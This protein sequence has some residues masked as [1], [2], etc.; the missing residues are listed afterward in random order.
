MLITEVRVFPVQEEKLK[1]FCSIVIDDA[2]VVSDIKLIEG[3]QGRFLSMPSVR[4]RNG[5]FRDIAHPLNAETRADIQRQV[6]AR[7]DAMLAGGE[8]LSER[9]RPV[10]APRMDEE[11]PPPPP[12]P[13]VPRRH[14]SL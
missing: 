11:P 1:A 13:L 14:A 2:F 8:I 3:R 6:F 9:P 10:L 7:Y 4:R 5:T 12:T